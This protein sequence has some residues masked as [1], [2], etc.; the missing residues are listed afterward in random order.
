MYG[1]STYGTSYAD[2]RRVNRTRPLLRTPYT[3]RRIR[4]PSGGNRALRRA[5]LPRINRN[6]CI[7]YASPRHFGNAYIGIPFEMFRRG[8]RLKACGAILEW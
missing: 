1:R 3:D 2:L 7:V 8:L 4:P 6:A 5:M